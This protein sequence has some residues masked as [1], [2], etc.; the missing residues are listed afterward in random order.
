MHFQ[1]LE[2]S[3]GSDES[4]CWCG[5]LAPL[6]ASFGSIEQERFYYL[7]G[8]SSIYRTFEWDTAITP[9]IYGLL[10][11]RAGRSNRLVDTDRWL[12]WSRPLVHHS[13]NDST[14]SFN[15]G[16][17]PCFLSEIVPFLLGLPVFWYLRWLF[18]TVL[19][20]RIN[21]FVGRFHWFAAAGMIELSHYVLT[22]LPWFWNE[23]VPYL[24][25]F[26]VFRRKQWLVRTAPMTRIRRYNVAFIRRLL[27]EWFNYLITFW[28]FHHGFTMR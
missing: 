27:Q 16:A 19:S 6:V 18:R 9:W 7:I 8:F 2:V 10:N 28:W 4:S 14:I 3:R 5:S 23:I 26:L 12:Y 15:F 21:G 20:I 1:S 24:G 22:N 17:S 11:P 13:R 25:G